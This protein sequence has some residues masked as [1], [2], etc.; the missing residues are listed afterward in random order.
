[1]VLDKVQGFTWLESLHLRFDRLIPPHLVEAARKLDR[2]DALKS[3]AIARLRLGAV[4]PSRSIA[5]AIMVRVI[6]SVA[7]SGR[8]ERQDFRAAGLPDDLIDTL[9]RQA[10]ARA[11]LLDPRLGD[12]LAEA[13]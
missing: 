12:L 2:A 10:Y 6:L 1:M 9:S 3:S 4:R 8:V 11:L 5:L 7:P 13:A